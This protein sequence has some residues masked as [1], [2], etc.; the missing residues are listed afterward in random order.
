MDMDFG[1]AKYIAVT[2]A[3]VA[4]LKVKAQQDSLEL[5]N[6]SVCL[7]SALAKSP[8]MEE[9]ADTIKTV[10]DENFTEVMLGQKNKS[11]NED[12]AMPWEQT[13]VGKDM[14][15][16]WKNLQKNSGGYGELTSD[17]IENLRKI[18]ETSH[19]TGA[20]SEGFKNYIMD[21]EDMLLANTDSL[22]LELEKSAKIEANGPGQRCYSWIKHILSGTNPIAWL[23]GQSAYEAEKWLDECP[24][25]VGVKSTYEH[26]NKIVPGG[27]A[28]FGKGFGAPDGHI[29]IGG[30]GPLELVKEYVT[31]FG[32]KYLYNPARDISDKNR[33]ANTTGKRGKKGHYAKNPKIYFTKNSTVS[34]QTLLKVGYKYAKDYMSKMFITPRDVYNAILQINDKSAEQMAQKILNEKNKVDGFVEATNKMAYHEYPAPRVVNPRGAKFTNVVTPTTQQFVRKTR[35]GNRRT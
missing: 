20:L 15:T 31:D 10:S 12:V 21:G 3:I 18:T 1:F 35:G 5:K 34:N 13:Q 28:V 23:E 33:N 16:T 17:D 7:T 27:I 29:L 19:Y 32:K 26:M 2:L 24:N 9:N 8:V 4:T 25:V 11:K 6:D 30:K 14:I 22:G